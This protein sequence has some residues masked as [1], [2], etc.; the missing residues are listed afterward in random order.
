[1]MDNVVILRGEYGSVAH[2]TA[3]D[4]SDHDY[5]EI[6]LETEEQVIGLEKFKSQRDSDA[7]EGERSQAGE[8]DT[9]TH[10]LRKFASLAAAGNPT[11][12]SLLHLPSYETL[13]VVGE[14]LL[15]I[16]DAFWSMR[17]GNAYLGYLTS[18]KAKIADYKKRPEIVEQY[19]Y[20]VKFA[21]HAYRLGVQGLQHMVARTPQIPLRGESLMVA[22]NIRGG[23][24]S[25]N[26]VEVLLDEVES[27]LAEVLEDAD[28]FGI[29][30]Q[31]DYAKINEFLVEAHQNYWYYSYALGG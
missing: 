7:A 17:L 24:Y 13:T 16:R 12:H 1:M 30:D 27:K 28:S 25:L 10:S 21:Y 2:G 19:G 4:Q 20:D 5:M 14:A 29:P 3:T 15:G 6:V 11:L 31:P 23:F 22:Q 9:T 18:Q 26:L 8:S